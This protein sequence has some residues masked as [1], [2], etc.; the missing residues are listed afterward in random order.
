MTQFT[1]TTAQQALSK[2]IDN[3][4]PL[5]RDRLRMEI[6]TVA[7]ALTLLQQYERTLGTIGNAIYHGDRETTALL[8][9]LTRIGDDQKEPA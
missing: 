9:R 2:L 6:E 5:Y 7:T 8:D 1:N 3:I 4:A